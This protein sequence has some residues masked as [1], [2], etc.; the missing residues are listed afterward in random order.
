MSFVKKLWKNRVSDYP[1][2]RL[3]TPVGQG[4]AFVAEIERNEGTITEEGDPFNA[5]TMNDLEQRIEDG[6]GAGSAAIAPEETSST[7]SRAYSVNQFLI[8]ND[9]LYKVIATIQQGA[10]LVPDTNIQEDTVGAELTAGIT[11]D[12]AQNN[13]INGLN[14]QLAYGGTKFYFDSKNGKWG[15]NS[16]PARGADTFHPFKQASSAGTYT[17]DALY[18]ASGAHPGSSSTIVQLPRMTGDG[19]L[20]ITQSMI[21]GYR[22]STEP[23]NNSISGEI[24]ITNTTRGTSVSYSREGNNQY[25]VNVTGKTL[26]YYAGDYIT[27]YCKA[28]RT[29]SW[30]AYAKFVYTLTE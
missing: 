25:S 10:T 14:G 28:E 5:A 6:I 4:D 20:A 8:Y 13:S 18:Y 15:W 16:S 24:T 9:K 1:T 22:D 29:T 7:A 26:N 21:S 27:I 30:H 11:T 3:I 12:N 2:R 19:V 23:E 17:I